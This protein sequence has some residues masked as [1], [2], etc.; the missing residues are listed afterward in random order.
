RHGPYQDDCTYVSSCSHEYG[1]PRDRTLVRV[2]HELPV[3]KSPKSAK[4]LWTNVGVRE[5]PYSESWLNY[6]GPRRT[7]WRT[8]LLSHEGRS[9]SCRGRSPTPAL[10]SRCPGESGSHAKL[11]S[12]GERANAQLKSW[13]L[14]RKL[15]CSPSKI[16]HLRKAAHVL[17]TAKPPQDEKGSVSLSFTSVRKTQSGFMSLYPATT[18]R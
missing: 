11:P 15:R 4:H 1:S 5:S 14:L 12:L 17:Q 9:S 10:D 13:K 3:T 6:L 2:R 18:V 7:S 16:G 8:R